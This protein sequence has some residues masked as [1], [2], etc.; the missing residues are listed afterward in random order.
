MNIIT[1]LGNVAGAALT[2]N[3]KVRKLSF[4]GS[5]A[6]G[7]MVAKPQQKDWCPSRWS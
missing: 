4:T 7:R 3:K 5:T 2:G 1:G 6:V